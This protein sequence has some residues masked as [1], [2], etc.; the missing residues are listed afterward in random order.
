MDNQKKFLIKIL[1]S[2]NPFIN[3]HTETLYLNQVAKDSTKICILFYE[4]FSSVILGRSM[5]AEK[6]IFLHKIKKIPVLKRG[7][8]G[9]TVMHFIGNLNYTL[10]VSLEKYPKLYPI[11][12]SYSLI[13][14]AICDELKPIILLEQKGLSDLS[15]QYRGEYYKISG[16][17][18][19]RKKGCLLHHGTFLYHT[20]NINQINYYLQQPKEQPEYRKNRSHDSFIIPRGVVCISKYTVISCFI[21]AMK[22]IKFT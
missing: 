21:K 12:E 17:S 22:Q 6:D 20:K 11:R 3:L 16:N 18:Q 4:N 7:S 5:L 1:S 10:I 2:K 8:G 9:G 19:I 14:K 15:M 13:L